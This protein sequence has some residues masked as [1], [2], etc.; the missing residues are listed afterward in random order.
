MGFSDGLFQSV[1]VVGQ[2]HECV[3]AFRIGLFQGFYDGLHQ[4][5]YFVVDEDSF[6]KSAIPDQ[7]RVEVVV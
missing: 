4:L 6:G 2:V 3:H 7:F 1:L 5:D